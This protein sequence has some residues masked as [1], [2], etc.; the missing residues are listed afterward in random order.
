MPTQMPRN[1]APLPWTA[2][3]IAS[4]TPGRASN[5]AMQAAKAPTPGNT[6]RSALAMTSGSSVTTTSLFPSA[7]R[8][9]AFSAERRLPD[10]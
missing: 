8:I 3:A 1:G 7:A 9:R 4:D 2:S 5:A 6:T 10:P